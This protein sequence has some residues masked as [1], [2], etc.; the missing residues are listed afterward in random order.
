[1][2]LFNWKKVCDKSAGSTN[3][4]VDIL[5]MLYKEKIPFNKYDPIY[6]YSD[7]DFSGDSFLLN[8]KELLENAFKYS[9]KEVAVY[10]ALAARRKLS[11]YLA[12]GTKTLSIPHAPQQH[13]LFKENRLLWLENNKVYFLY[14]EVHRRQ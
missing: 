4:I 5:E 8:P 10:T 7:I 2:L 6:K 14:E 11:D 9:S 3:A 1:M 12:F 13:Q